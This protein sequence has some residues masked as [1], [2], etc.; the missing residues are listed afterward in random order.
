MFNYSYAIQRCSDNNLKLLLS[1]I[2]K[3]AEYS[4]LSEA[5][6][7]GYKKFLELECFKEKTIPVAIRNFYKFMD[8]GYLFDTTVL[9]T[10]GTIRDTTVKIQQIR[11]YN[12]EPFRENVGLPSKYSVYAIASY[13]DLFCFCNDGQNDI[14]QWSVANHKIVAQWNNFYIWLNQEINT[15]VDLVS[16]GVLMPL[17]MFSGGDES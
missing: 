15:A 9:S 11:A 13:G 17:G 6:A 16:E 3:F 7:T 8:G 5:T 14:I 12:N 4:L 1:K 10:Q 2:E